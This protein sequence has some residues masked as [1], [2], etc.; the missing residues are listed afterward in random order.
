MGSIYRSA[1]KSKSL[2]PQRA[3]LPSFFKKI[4]HVDW[5]IDWF[6][7]CT[8]VCLYG[9]IWSQRA[10]SKNPSCPS[11][12]GSWKWNVGPKGLVAG[13]FTYQAILLALSFLLNSKH[14]SKKYN[15]LP[16]NFSSVLSSPTLLRQKFQFFMST[17]YR[18]KYLK[19]IIIMSFT[20]FSQFFSLKSQALHISISP[21]SQLFG[22]TFLSEVTELS[23][24]L[25]LKI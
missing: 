6:T 8:G 7:L 20:N 17:I 3:N 15:F 10:T 21:L 24:V 13:T 23:I 25:Q 9:S 18:K 2:H 5:L 12:T 11:T 19:I 16:E 14:F 22:K 1:E 4:L